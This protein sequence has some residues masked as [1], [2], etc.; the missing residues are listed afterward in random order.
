[1]KKEEKQKKGLEKRPKHLYTKGRLQC[2]LGTVG[3]AVDL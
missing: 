3:S 1:M 2:R